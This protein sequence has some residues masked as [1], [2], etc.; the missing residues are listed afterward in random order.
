MPRVQFSEDYDFT[1]AAAPHG[2]TMA[3]KAGH[4]LT[5]EQECADLAVSLGHATI[6]EG[7]GDDEGEPST[8]V[9]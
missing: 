7:G 8:E 2:P 3:Y 5:V 4:C 9:G 6:V 1:P